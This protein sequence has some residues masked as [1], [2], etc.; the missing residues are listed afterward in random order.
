[1]ETTTTATVETAGP[2]DGITV[3]DLSRALAGPYATALLADMGASVIK[4]ESIKGGDS[5]RSWPPFENEHSLYFDSV[6]RGKSSVAIDFYSPEGKDL[7]RKL[8]LEADVLI[9]N[10]RPGVLTT[11]GLDP[12][13]LRAIKPGL[14]IA[15][16]T[17]FGTTGPLAR[18]AGLD[19]VAQGMSGLMSVT[20]G[21]AGNMYRFGVPIVDMCAGIFTAYGIASALTGRARTGEGLDISTSLLETALAL[22]AFQGQRYLSN[23]EVPVPQGND[24]PVL[25]PYGVFKTADIPVI[26]SVGNDKQWLQ[27]CALVGDPA[28]AQDPSYMTGR[29][30]SINRQAL[31]GRL[32]DLLK[33]RPGLEWLEAFR[34]AK[35]P[36]GPIYNYAEVFADPQVQAVDMVRTVSRYD[37]TELPLLRGPLSVNGEPTP[38]TKAPPALGEDTRRVLQDL[39]LTPGQIEKLV[40]SGIVRETT[41]L[42]T[43]HA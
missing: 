26:I 33:K 31:A 17:G 5:S 18:T 21:D 41:A 30:R 7:L 35:I 25:A 24:H 40:A 28:L 32:E 11:M 29:D 14:I 22:S 13:A 36:C 12:E 15:S 27:L 3:L 42:G 10:F 37:G 1:M 23:G 38:V 19:Q 39:A 4:V 6:N 34:A 16:V 43:V 8:A 20:G 9:E 2:L